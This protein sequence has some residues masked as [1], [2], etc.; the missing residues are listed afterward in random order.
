MQPLI[1]F[2]LFHAMTGSSRLPK[3]K[4]YLQHTHTPPEGRAKTAVVTTTSPPYR[5]PSSTRKKSILLKPPTLSS[6]KCS[7]AL[8]CSAAVRSARCRLSDAPLSVA[9]RHRSP[10]AE[11][12]QRSRLCGG[13]WRR[14]FLLRCSYH[15]PLRFFWRFLAHPLFPRQPSLQRAQ[16]LPIFCCWLVVQQTERGFV[17]PS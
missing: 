16:D 2:F 10:R 8:Q 6:L 1:N 17:R 13:R 9:A 5:P 14:G 4:L 7:A 15:H 3:Q 11:S 12:R